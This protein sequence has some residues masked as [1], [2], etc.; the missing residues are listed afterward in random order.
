MFVLRE[1][2]EGAG[3]R[4]C[5]RFGS[6]AIGTR[7]LWLHSKGRDPTPLAARHGATILL[8]EDEPHCIR[9][10]QVFSCGSGLRTRPLDGYPKAAEE[11]WPGR[12]RWWSRT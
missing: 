6:S 12:G 5:G 10:S 3:L 4:F 9:P 8:R 2:F 11:V 1:G 7:S